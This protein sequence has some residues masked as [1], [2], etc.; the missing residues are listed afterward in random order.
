MIQPIKHKDG[1]T[2]NR[3][4]VN[5]EFCGYPTARHVARFCTDFISS[6][7]TQKE[8]IQALEKHKNSYSDSFYCVDCGE[9]LTGDDAKYK[10]CHKCGSTISN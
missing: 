5:L 4:T 8:A 10:E 2:D 3:Y 9:G 7:V 6:H 1:T